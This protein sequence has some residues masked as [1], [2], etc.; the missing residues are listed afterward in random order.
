MTNKPTQNTEALDFEFWMQLAKEDPESFERR[1]Q[2]RVAQLIEQ[3]PSE[4]RR[5]LQGLQWQIDQARKLANG[6]IAACMAISNMMWDSLHELNEQ[7]HE[8]ITT[9]LNSPH[10][11]QSA[12]PAATL[13]SFPVSH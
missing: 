8:L 5:R 7:Q 6:P 11:K 2:E 9:P 3:A 10:H 13:L 4:Q 12:R 1:R